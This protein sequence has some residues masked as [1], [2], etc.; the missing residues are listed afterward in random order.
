VT[1]VGDLRDETA[2][3]YCGIQR[4]V[5]VLEVSVF[6]F[7][8]SSRARKRRGVTLMLDCQLG[9]LHAEREDEGGDDTLSFEEEHV[10]QPG[11]VG[12]RL[13]NK[14]R[15]RAQGCRNPCLRGTSHRHCSEVA[16]NGNL[17][18]LLL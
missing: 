6:E 2:A 13:E 4:E 8:G 18:V 7:E 15:N 17:L 16:P 14:R 12:T 1:I 3:A 11:A 9:T 5:E 10:Q